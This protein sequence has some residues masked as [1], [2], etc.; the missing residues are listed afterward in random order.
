MCLFYQKPVEFLRSSLT[1]YLLPSPATVPVWS[2]VRECEH[3][4]DSD[5]TVGVVILNYLHMETYFANV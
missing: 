3:C 4:T 5:R 2:T 1:T